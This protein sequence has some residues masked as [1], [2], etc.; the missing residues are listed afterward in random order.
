MTQSSAATHLRLVGQEPADLS[1][2]RARE[3]VIRENRRAAQQPDLDPTDPR[4]VL[5]VRVWSQLDGSALTPDRRERLLATA[6]RLGLRPFDANVIIAVVQDH[7]RRGA[8][9][10]DAADTLA[11]VPRVEPRR[12]GRDLTLHD[13][14]RGR[15]GGRRARGARDVGARRRRLT[16][17]TPFALRPSAIASRTRAR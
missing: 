5:A 13:G 7:A 17:L 1:A 12:L 8:T 4:W 16:A 10:A 15:R 3:A 6:R 14:R 2:R 11:N 9:L